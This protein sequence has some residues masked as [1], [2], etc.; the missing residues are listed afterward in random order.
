MLGIEYFKV[1]VTTDGTLKGSVTGIYFVSCFSIDQ[2]G[3]L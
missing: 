2:G 1:S 3:E